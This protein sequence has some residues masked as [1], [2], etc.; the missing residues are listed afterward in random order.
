MCP[1]TIVYVESTIA[2]I[3]ASVTA[4]AALVTASTGDAEVETSGNLTGA[5]LTSRAS[6]A[7]DA[8]RNARA[9]FSNRLTYH[10]EGVTL[11][12]SP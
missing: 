9:R 12:S 5:G 8:I 10:A 6:T 7:A 4:C 2:Q 11:A 3:N 1:E